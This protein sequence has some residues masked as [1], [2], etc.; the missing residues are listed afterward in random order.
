MPA[1]K[2]NMLS[3]IICLFLVWAYSYLSIKALIFEK[4]EKSYWFEYF[5]LSAIYLLKSS[6]PLY[7]KA[8]GSFTS[9]KKPLY[10]SAL[11]NHIVL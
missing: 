8:Y 7:R 6:Y 3:P 10:G 5:S 9:A 4:T 1:S 11:P 2:W